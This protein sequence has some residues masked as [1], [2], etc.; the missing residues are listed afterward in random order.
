MSRKA[1]LMRMRGK[2]CTIFQAESAPVPPGPNSAHAEQDGFERFMQEYANRQGTDLED[3]RNESASP[4]I[5][6]AAPRERRL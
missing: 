2:I 4:H 5:E 6:A 1:S 3:V